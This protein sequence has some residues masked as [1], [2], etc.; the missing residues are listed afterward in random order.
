MAAHS[1]HCDGKFGL[2]PA[3]CIAANEIINLYE[4]RAAL[5]QAAPK[6]GAAPAEHAGARA[7][8]RPRYPGRGR[9]RPLHH[10]GGG[11]AG[12]RLARRAGELFPHQD[13]LDR[14]GNALRHG[15]CHRACGEV[16]PGGAQ[17][18]RSFAAFPG[19]QPGVFLEPQLSG[20]GRVG[21]CRAQRAGARAHSPRRIRQVSQ[22]SGPGLDPHP[23]R[24]RLCRARWSR[25]S[26]SSAFICCA[27]W[28]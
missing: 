23:R 7:Q 17:R 24:R 1:E 15:Q 22:G 28:R 12:R 25:S 21:A 14:G 13:R 4:K 3:T 9:L 5:A 8:G 2:A 27:A 18:G 20:Y 26:S 19:R 10:D 11:G 6:S 16:R